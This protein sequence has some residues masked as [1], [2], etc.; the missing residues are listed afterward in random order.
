[1][2][3]NGDAGSFGIVDTSNL[4]TEANDSVCDGDGSHPETELLFNYCILRFLFMGTVI[5]GLKPEELR[6]SI[7]APEGARSLREGG[8]GSLLSRISKT[9]RYGAP[10]HTFSSRVARKEQPQ[11][12]RPR[13]ASLEMTGSEWARCFHPSPKEGNLGHSVRKSAVVLSSI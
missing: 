2:T 1:M 4:E 10:G 7:R 12:S 8:A 3:H 9:G 5:P 6:S 13:C 11:I